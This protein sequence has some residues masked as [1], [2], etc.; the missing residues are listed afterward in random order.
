MLKIFFNTEL[1]ERGAEEMKGIAAK[2]GT[3]L[4]NRM[5]PNTLSLKLLHFK[6]DYFPASLKANV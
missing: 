6:L 1:V 2:A 4:L 3:F 5:G